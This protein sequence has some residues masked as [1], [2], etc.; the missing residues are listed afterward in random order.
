MGI[1]KL[2][3]IGTKIMGVLLF[4]FIVGGL[5]YIKIGEKRGSQ[6]REWFY[7]YG[8]FAIGKITGHQY[9]QNR[10]MTGVL[11]EYNPYNKMIKLSDHLNYLDKNQSGVA[12]GYSIGVKNKR[13]LV[14]FDPQNPKKAIIRIDYPVNDSAE[15][16][17]YVD[18]F[19]LRRTINITKEE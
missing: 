11:F 5:I 12:S 9:G 17:R 15:F 19:K 8:E 18:E 3:E 1:N 2:D 16:K 14:L 6:K 7:E 13:Y 4:I 10:I